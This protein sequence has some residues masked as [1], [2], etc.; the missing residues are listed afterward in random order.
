MLTM[1]V[2]WLKQEPPYELEF[3]GVSE[4]FLRTR[5]GASSTQ[6]ISKRFHSPKDLVALGIAGCTGVDV[7]SIL[8]KMRQ[9]LE[10]LQIDTQLTQTDEHP[11]VFEKCTL[12]Y[13]FAGAGLER[14]RVIRAAALSFGKYCGVSAMIKRSGCSFEPRLELNGTDY[15]FEFNEALDALNDDAIHVQSIQSKA[16]FRAAVLITGNELLR[17][18]TADTNGYFISKQISS[19]GMD[20]SELK[21]IGDDR[22]KL[23]DEL[24]ALSVD[25]DFIFITGG[26]GPTKDDLT[27]EVVAQAFYLPLEYSSSAWDVC[28]RAFDRMGRTEI[29]ESNKKQ[30]FLPKGAQVLENTFGTAAGFFVKQEFANR[31]CSV[32]SLPGVPWECEEMFLT[33]VK[34]HLPLISS[35]RQEWG[36]WHVWGI[37]ESALQTQL[38]VLERDLSQTISGINFSYQAHAGYISY[39]FHVSKTKYRTEEESQEIDLLNYIDRFEGVFGK[40]LLYKGNQTLNERLL[41]NFVHLGITLCVAESCTGGRIATELSSLAGASSFFAGGIVAYSNLAKQ[42]LLRVTQTTLDQFGAVSLE[43][44]AEMALGSQNVF[45]SSIALSVTGIAG[46]SGGSHEKPVGMVCFSLSLSTSLLNSSDLSE[47]VETLSAQG[48]QLFKESGDVLLFVVEKRFG[49]FLSRSLVQKRALVFALCSLV[50][51]SESMRRSRLCD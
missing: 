4:E 11:R 15:S 3:E 25:N 33:R 6:G 50:S 35:D 9:P 26:L 29:P 42:K 41:E 18:K 1:S 49:S 19:M 14:D 12:T 24:R 13:K 23:V 39:G 36:P 44:A 22:G 38:S 2:R 43:T 34:P 40:R 16:S 10:E 8:K 30:A 32:F 37:G 5:T 28:L 51:V 20:V 47:I 17:G 45:A 27:S 21:I 48:W 46:P 31:S 7:V